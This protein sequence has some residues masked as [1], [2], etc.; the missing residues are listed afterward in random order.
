MEHLRVDKAEPPQSMAAGVAVVGLP[1][2]EPRQSVPRR[3]ATSTT[4]RLTCMLTIAV[5]WD[6]QAYAHRL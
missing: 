4:V 5:C 1:G 6:V 3:R 2:F